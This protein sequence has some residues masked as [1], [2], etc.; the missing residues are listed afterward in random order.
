MGTRTRAKGEATKEKIL[1]QVPSIAPSK[2]EIFEIEYTSFRSVIAF[3][4]AIKKSTS[5]LDCVLLSAGLVNPAYEEITE[6]GVGSWDIALKVNVLSAALLAI[7][8]LPLLK[9]TPGSILNFV[10]SIGFTNVTSQ[11]IKPALDAIRSRKSDAKVLE[12]FNDAQRWKPEESYC[13]AK[14]LLMFVLQGI[15]EALG[16][17][18]GKLASPGAGPVALVCCPNQTKTDL[19]RNFPLSMKIMMFAWNS[20]FGRTAEQGSRTLVSG[21]MLGE[22]ANGKFWTNDKLDERS[23]NI[24][25]DEW[26]ILQKAAWNEILEVLRSFK[27]DLKI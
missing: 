11:Q 16:G 10:G 3:A 22:E 14:L 6:E 4:E 24:T 23:P 2:I 19:G 21:L 8:L 27:P 18:Q 15:V 13:E 25:A 5:T 20:V 17:S 9:K 1:K 7:E 26:K 12:F